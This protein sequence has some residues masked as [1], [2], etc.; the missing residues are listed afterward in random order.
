MMIFGSLGLLNNVKA[1][2]SYMRSFLNF[3]LEQERTKITQAD[4]DA[5]ISDI[6]G[7]RQSGQAAPRINQS[8]VLMQAHIITKTNKISYKLVIHINYTQIHKNQNKPRETPRL[9]DQ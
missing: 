9:S 4:V 7:S 8:L 2:Q 6:T 1:E 3:L 5:I